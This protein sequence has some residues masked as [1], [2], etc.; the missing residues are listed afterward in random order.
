MA[1]EQQ[2]GRMSFSFVQRSRSNL[3]IRRKIVSTIRRSIGY[4]HAARVQ[5]P[6]IGFNGHADPSRDDYSDAARKARSEFTILR[7][8]SPFMNLGEH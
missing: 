3:S 7:K 2:H 8:P 5:S 1:F 4:L 6:K